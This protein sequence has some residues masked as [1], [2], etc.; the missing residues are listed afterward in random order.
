M[1][2]YTAPRSA[3]I[4]ISVYDL[5]GKEIAVPVNGQ[6]PAGYH[7]INLSVLNLSSGIYFYRMQ[8]VDN[9]VSNT[10]KLGRVYKMVVVK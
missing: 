2:R 6:M 9:T 4:K 5:L 10:L 8:V 1:I 7:E 3:Y